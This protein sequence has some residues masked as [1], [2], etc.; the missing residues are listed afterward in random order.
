MTPAIGEFEVMLPG[1]TFSST[2]IID[3]ITHSFQGSFN[4]AA[5]LPCKGVV[6]LTYVTSDD[7]TSTR[8]FKGVFDKATV[9]ITLANG[10]VIT[11]VVDNPV[12]VPNNVTGTG[13]WGVTKFA[14]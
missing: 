1:R 6:T 11:G 3:E 12:P 10:V 9:T 14:D 8:D 5:V 7:L 13:R 4:G 2:F